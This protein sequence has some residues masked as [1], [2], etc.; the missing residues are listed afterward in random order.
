MPFGRSAL[1]AECWP[2]R[3]PAPICKGRSN[4][5]SLFRLQERV[6]TLM[7]RGAALD[8][9]ESEVI[10]GSGLD[11]DQKAALW[12]YAWSFVE[13]REQREQAARYLAVTGD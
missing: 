8:R 10:E 1:G 13:N 7:Q 4:V 6:A 5:A 2:R 12:L 3:Q 11:S 9:I